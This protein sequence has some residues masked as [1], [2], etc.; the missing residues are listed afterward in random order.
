MRKWNRSQQNK[1]ISS[2]PLLKC[3]SISFVFSLMTGGIFGSVIREFWNFWGSNI[4]AP[5]VFHVAGEL[6]GSREKSEQWQKRQAGEVKDDYN[7]NTS[8]VN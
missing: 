3:L 8:F 4:V 2:I 6:V 7:T 1:I 5:K